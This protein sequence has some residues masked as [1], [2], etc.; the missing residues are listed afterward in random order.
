[1]LKCQCWFMRFDI[2]LFS[3]T[4]AIGNEMGECYLF[5]LNSKDVTEVSRKVM[6]HGLCKKAIRQTTFSRDGSVLIFV[7]DDGKIWRWDRK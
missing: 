4:L 6:K 1:M 3:G 2:H 7:T 5:D